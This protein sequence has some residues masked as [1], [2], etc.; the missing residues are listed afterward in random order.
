MKSLP[1]AVAALVSVSFA[2][3]A[4]PAAS[5]ATATAAQG[6]AAP[7]SNVPGSPAP[8]E[9]PDDEP[10][11]ELIPPAKDTL[12]GHVQLGASGVLAVPFARLDSDT[13]FRNQA[14]GGYGFAADLG[15]GVSRSVVVGAFGQYLRM[16]DGEG[17]PG[18]DPTALGFGAFVRYHLVQGVRFDPWASLGAGY[19][20]FDTGE[21]KYS[22][23]EW[24]R[25]SVGGDWYA[26]SQVGFGPYI[27][28]DFGTFTERP[29]GTDAAVYANFAGGL[30]VVVDLQGK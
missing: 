2:A 1:A 5:P 27:E 28:L 3:G 23:I 20:L 9:T 21:T 22:G 25:L 15:I 11:P 16:N 19:R 7:P 8:S 29:S 12:G 24:L 18:C 14:E 6:Q 10:E 30:R 26:L 13:T 17:C 4:A